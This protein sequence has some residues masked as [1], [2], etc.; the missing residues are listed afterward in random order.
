MMSA[1][2]MDVPVETLYEKAWDEYI[3]AF[4]RATSISGSYMPVDLVHGAF[5]EIHRAVNALVQAKD[6]EVKFLQKA[7]KQKVDKNLALQAE[8]ER[9]YKERD[10]G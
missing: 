7:Y 2:D 8:I 10:D 1:H 4:N 9:L 5:T 3:L 6:E